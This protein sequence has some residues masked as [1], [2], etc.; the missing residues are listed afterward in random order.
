M[1][2]RLWLVSLFTSPLLL[3][4][5]SSLLPT[6]SYPL[7]TSVQAQTTQDQTA[8][9][10][11]LLQQ[12][13]QQFDISQYQ[14]AIQSWQQALVIYQKLGNRNGEANSLGSLGIA[15]TSLGE[16]AKAIVF[17]QQ[18]LNIFRDLGDRNSQA[19]LLGNLGAT[20]FSLGQYAKAIVQNSP[21]QNLN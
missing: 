7:S 14:A 3:T 9:A 17:F 10:D 8:E 1:S 19:D 15:Y 6:S 18:S 2:L 16:Y 5:I 12:G 21:S 13:Y 20:Y 4:L 11:R